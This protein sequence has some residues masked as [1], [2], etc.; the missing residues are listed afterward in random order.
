MPSLDERLHAQLDQMVAERGELDEAIRQLRQIISGLRTPAAKPVPAAPKRPVKKK[1]VMS[2]ADRLAQVRG[3]LDG[4]GGAMTAEEIG[5][6][7]GL[8]NGSTRER[9]KDLIDE[10]IVRPGPERVNKT[11]RNSL[12]YERVPMAVAPPAFAQP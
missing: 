2:K 8:N 7:I 1:K 9:L 3:T 4:N 6:Q 12:T 5:K 11:G 10:G